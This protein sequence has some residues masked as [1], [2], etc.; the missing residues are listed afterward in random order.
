MMGCPT[1]RQV[2]WNVDTV[3]MEQDNQQ[4]CT[5]LYS[6]CVQRNNFCGMFL[7]A[8][9]SQYWNG[10]VVNLRRCHACKRWTDSSNVCCTDTHTP[11]LSVCIGNA[12]SKHAAGYQV[13]VLVLR[14]ISSAILETNSAVPQYCCS[15]RSSAIIVNIWLVSQ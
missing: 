7:D 9:D 11:S 10:A 14:V 6:G 12:G 3:G 1:H 15:T 8:E 4:T 5:V 2:L 13:M